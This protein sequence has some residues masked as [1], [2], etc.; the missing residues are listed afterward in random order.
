MTINNAA[1]STQTLSNVGTLHF[2]HGGIYQ[3]R[4]SNTVQ[5]RILGTSTLPGTGFPPLS[6]SASAQPAAFWFILLLSIFTLLL[7]LGGIGFSLL[8]RN[9][10]WA[11]WSRQMGL[12]ISL[13]GGLF[14]VFALLVNQKGNSPKLTFPTAS[15]LTLKPAPPTAEINAPAFQDLSTL[16]DYPIPTPTSIPAEVNGQAPDDSPP[17]RILI[18]ALGLDT[19]VK[20]VPFD[21]FTWLISGLQNE[22]AW[23]GSTS[24]PGLGGNTGLAGHVTLRNGSDG[25]FRHLDSLQAN[26]II[27][28]ITDRNIYTYQVRQKQ[29]V[30]DDDFSIIQPSQQPI[31]TLITCTGWNSEF[32]HYLQRLAVVAD[33]VEMKPLSNHSMVAP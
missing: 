24:W 26:D 10:P 17:N 3:F 12:L 11:G 22:I 29:V 6:S 25:P 13:A 33:L 1:S 15:P 19:V 8:N 18:P 31:L 7:G 30:N 2:Y 23:M 5:Y 16:P 32:G 20:Y 28:V 21:G 4:Q 27:T 14:F 9:S